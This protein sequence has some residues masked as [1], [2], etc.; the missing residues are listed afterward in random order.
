MTPLAIAA[1]AT[2]AASAALYLRR[3]RWLDAALATTA[4]CAL[5]GLLTLPSAATPDVDVLTVTDDTVAADVVRARG[6]A[7]AGH[8]LFEAQWR[9]LPARPLAWQAPR[10]E[11][12]W[13]DFPRTVA[14]GRAFAL[15]ARRSAAPGPWRLQLLAENGAVLHETKGEGPQLT[16]QWLPPLAER[17]VLRARL[18]DGAGKTLHEG[19][20][21]LTVV[22]SVPL[23]V[24]GR[25]GS[26][27][28]DTRV[29]NELLAASG[30]QLDWRTVLGKAVTRSEGAASMTA[31]ANA[32]VIDAAWF[33]QQGGAGRAALLAQVAQGMPLLVLGGNAATPAVWREALALRLVEQSATTEQEDTRH[34]MAGDTVLAL[35]PAA[36]HPVASADWTV[37]AADRAGK[38]WAWQRPWRQGRVAWLDVAGWHR[39]AITAPAGVALWW[40]EVLDLATRG[41]P[42][43]I[44]W[45]QPDPLPLPGLR[46]ELC[47]HGVR[48]GS[49][50]TVDGHGTLTWQARADR[51]GAVCAA[52]WPRQPGWIAA[53]AGKETVDTF[54]YAA[55]D[56]PAWQRALRHEA[57]QRYAARALPGA[58]RTGAATAAWPAWPF[59]LLLAGSLLG[60]WWRER[61]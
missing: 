23:H 22:P 31:P 61:R 49:A 12:L 26:A 28:F 33:E 13:L 57:T 43:Q 39:H 27:S 1:I 21:P 35:A 58:V 34:V 53:R 37:L 16:V 50:L 32:A 10:D 14:L 5:A 42:T 8:G 18:L 44:G 4:G 46:T 51:G 19:P 7:V 55:T 60:L 45:V 59:A 17:M 40:Q 11:L 24:L 29:L 30:A 25:F 2:G 9:D 38:P 36:W 54:V 47:A 20:V 52:F 3:R 15:T 56:W 48:P 6:I 41:S